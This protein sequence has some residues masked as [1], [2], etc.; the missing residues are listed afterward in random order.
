ML[1]YVVVCIV[2]W[3]CYEMVNCLAVARNSGSSSLHNAAVDVRLF[4][5]T[6]IVCN[7]GSVTFELPLER[8]NE[9]L[10]HIRRSG[11]SECKTNNERVCNK[12]FID[13]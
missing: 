8:R 3:Y 7:Q 5:L 10:A 1:P 4:R 11:L 2:G 6:A 13:S 12:D 9:W